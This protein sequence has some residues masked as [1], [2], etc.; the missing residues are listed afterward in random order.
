MDNIRVKVGKKYHAIYKELTQETGNRKKVFAQ[1]GDLFMLCVALGHSTEEKVTVSRDALFWSHSLTKNQQT[2]LKAIA[3]KESD[4][5]EVLS[6]PESIIQLAETLADRGMDD[7]IKTVLDDF[8][9]GEG[10]DG[11]SL[12][13]TDKDNLHK[14]ILSFVS[15]R[16]LASPF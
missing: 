6:R 13:F 8:I 5:Y 9:A 1:H 12:V 4:S 3:V 7:L 2:V 16:I 15:Q 11:L 14:T 10:D